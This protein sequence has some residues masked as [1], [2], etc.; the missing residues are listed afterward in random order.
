MI[1]FLIASAFANPD[2]EELTSHKEIVKY[3]GDAA[4]TAFVGLS[5]CAPDVAKKYISTT[6]PTFFGTEEGTQAAVVAVK[7]GGATTVLDWMKT[8]EPSEQKVLLRSLGNDCQKDEVVRQMF[9]DVAANDPERFWGNRFYQYL[10]ECRVESIQT[11]LQDKFH[12]GTDQGY[13]QYFGVA[14][15]YA[16]NLESVSIPILSEALANA[17]D[18]NVQSNLIS[19]ISEAVTTTL[20]NHADDKKLVRD[21][22]VAGVDAI[23]G[24]AST[25]TPEALTQARISLTALNA[26]AEVD[27]LAGFYYQSYK[28]PDGNL[29]WGLVIVEDAV[30]KKGKLKQ[31]I[32]VSSIVEPGTNW[33]DTLVDRVQEPAEYQW[34]L[35]LGEE[36]KGTSEIKYLVTDKPVHNQEELL[37]WQ[38]EQLTTHR[39]T[40]LKKIVLLEVESLGL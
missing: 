19:A 3:T 15:V 11:V 39:N 23:F 9:L 36:C 32:H 28:Q 27:E 37:V 24:K 6:V 25:L 20:E 1:Q 38:Q 2:C 13:S 30:C 26:E 10:S 35:K 17:T 16:R 22:N 14:S 21:V 34:G 31:R 29:L 12:E 33:A 8:L 40:E 18:G 4:A 5:E 7:L